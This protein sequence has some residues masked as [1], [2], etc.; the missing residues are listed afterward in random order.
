M[1]NVSVPEVPNPL[2]ELSFLT[3]E[4]GREFSVTRY[5]YVGSAS[6]STL[7]GA[8]LVCGELTRF[9]GFTYLGDA[10]GRVVS[11]PV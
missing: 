1:S 3:P 9:G 11:F 10:L 6:V 4:I 5:V 2:A 7:M 8:L